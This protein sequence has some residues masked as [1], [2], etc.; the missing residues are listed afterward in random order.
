MSQRYTA[1]QAFW[2]TPELIAICFD[3]LDNGTLSACARLSKRLSEHALDALYRDGPG[4]VRMLKLLGD[5]DEDEEGMLSFHDDITPAHWD[6]FRHYSS[7]VQALAVDSLDD[8]FQ[9]LTSSA[10]V[11][12][13]TTLPPGE[14]LLPSLRRLHWEDASWR[15]T[16]FITILLHERLQVI[17]LT[18][19]ESDMELIAE[20]NTLHLKINNSHLWD[21]D[22]EDIQKAIA[23]VLRGFPCLQSIALPACLASIDT[24][25]SLSRNA[26]I[27]RLWLTTFA[28][29][30][31]KVDERE[32]QREKIC[33][34]SP[35]T[36]AGLRAL[37]LDSTTFI[38]LSKTFLGGNMTG[39][40]SLHVEISEENHLPTCLTFVSTA[41]PNL[42]DLVVIYA[43]WNP[44]LARSSFKGTL[45][46]DMLE[47]LLSMRRL[48]SLV[49]DHPEPP[50]LS[51]AD[52]A[53]FARSF[54]ELRHLEL[55]VHAW[56]LRPEKIPTLSCLLS[57]AEHC[58]KLIS[59]G[60]YMDAAVRPP[61]V[62][63]D[64]KA[65]ASSLRV[66]QVFCSVIG[67]NHVVDY[68][69]A[70]LPS[71]AELTQSRYSSRLVPVTGELSDHF[72]TLYSNDGLEIPH[73]V[74]R[75][76]WRSASFLL[77]D[78]RNVRYLAAH[79]RKKNEEA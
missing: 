75:D 24:I 69:A 1:L 32:R 20:L 23:E 39:L 74:W 57:F 21:Y 6:R 10:M 46:M 52:L 5:M 41:Y 58:R 34:R 9:C 62:G 43:M 61:I 73:I 17:H 14:V 35:E 60:I 79:G 4:Y 29:R 33:D 51:D 18:I 27:V 28:I 16:P 54:P 76:K 15:T 70:I 59:I 50:E 12:L 31:T 30:E 3:F 66:M 7:R 53:R 71:D 44:Q 63:P 65:F 68:L 72:P 56:G 36:F 48:E 22:A 2:E 26:N 11:D 38:G 37:S 45:T 25:C 19:E 55:C 47:P 78:L 64:Q 67:D 40:V 49:L 8:P 13:L 77:A 42:R